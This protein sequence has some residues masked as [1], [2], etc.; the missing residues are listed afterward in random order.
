MAGGGR[1]DEI[2]KLGRPSLQLCSGEIIE[3]D[4]SIAIPNA[5][6]HALCSG[7]DRYHL[8][9]MLQVANNDVGSSLSSRD[10]RNVGWRGNRLP[11]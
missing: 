11:L 3:E 8:I 7:L 1:I 6:H 10:R 5:I 9:A 2:V 4:F